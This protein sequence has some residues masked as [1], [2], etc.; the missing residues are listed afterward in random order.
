[1]FFKDEKLKKFLH[2]RLNFL[3]AMVWVVVLSIIIFSLSIFSFVLFQLKT[4]SDLFDRLILNKSPRATL[5]ISPEL[6][7]VQ[8]GED[9]SVDIMLN[10]KGNNVVA[11]SAYLSYNKENL[12][13][14]ELNL[15]DSV[16]DL[17]AEKKLEP[18]DGKVKITM[19]KPTPGVNVNRGKVASIHFKALETNN[20]SKDNIYF[21]FTYGSSLYSTAILD[22]KLGT[23][24]LSSVRGSRIHIEE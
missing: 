4:E 6:K 11:S 15:S 3:R 5:Y 14:L 24:I 2:S 23:N 12:E 18:K 20:P 8:V 1:M 21:D 16:F 19:G 22:N 7:K 13:V 9:F 10:T 17:V